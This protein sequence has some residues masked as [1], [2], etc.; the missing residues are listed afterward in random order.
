MRRPDRFRMGY[1][2]ASFATSLFL[3][4]SGSPSG[5]AVAQRAEQPPGQVVRN[6]PP[7]AQDSPVRKEVPSDLSSTLT[8]GHGLS[9][10]LSGLL[11]AIFCEWTLI[12]SSSMIQRK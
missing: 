7:R 12:Y 6:D 8:A 10:F 4:L 5:T 1:A 9:E 11:D 2:L 3:G